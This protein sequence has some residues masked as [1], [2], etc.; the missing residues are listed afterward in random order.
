THSP[1]SHLVLYCGSAGLVDGAAAGPLPAPGAAVP[2]G[3]TRLR[4]CCIAAGSIT[5]SSVGTNTP[6]FTEPGPATVSPTFTSASVML[7]PPPPGPPGP[8]PPGPAPPGR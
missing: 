8:A 7:S 2:S 4:R 3:F 5:P 1:H 6:F